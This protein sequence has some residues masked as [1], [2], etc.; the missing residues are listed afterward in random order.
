MIRQLVMRIMELLPEQLGKIFRTT[1]S[2]RCAEQKKKLS[3]KPTD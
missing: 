1:G 2:A 3:G